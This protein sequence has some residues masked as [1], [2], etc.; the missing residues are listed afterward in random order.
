[1][2]KIEQKDVNQ[3]NMKKIITLALIS[4][5][6]SNIKDYATNIPSVIIEQVDSK[7]WKDLI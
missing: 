1:M 5:I 3:F 4:I 6:T 7:K 2:T